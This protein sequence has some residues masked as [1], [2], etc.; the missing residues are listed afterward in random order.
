MSYTAQLQLGA[1]LLLHPGLNED[2]GIIH[3]VCVKKLM[4]YARG[5]AFS[6]THTYVEHPYP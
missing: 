4:F 3:M 2:N 1:L 5:P 6:S